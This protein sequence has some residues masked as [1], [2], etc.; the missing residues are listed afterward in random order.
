MRTKT[1]KPTLQTPDIEEKLYKRHRK[2]GGVRLTK[3]RDML[4]FRPKR[5]RDGTMEKRADVFQRRTA[6]VQTHVREDAQVPY[7][8]FFGMMVIHLRSCPRSPPRA[9]VPVPISLPLG[10]KVAPLRS[11]LPMPIPP[12]DIQTGG[13]A[14]LPNE[15]GRGKRGKGGHPTDWPYDGRG[16]RG[17][18]GHP[19]DWPYD[20]LI[21]AVA[22]WALKHR[23]GVLRPRQVTDEC[24]AAVQLIARE[25][26][27]HVGAIDWTLRP[28]RESD[29][30]ESDERESDELRFS[31]DD[32]LNQLT[33]VYIIASLKAMWGIPLSDTRRVVFLMILPRPSTPQPFYRALPKHNIILER[34]EHD[35]V[36]FRVGSSVSPSH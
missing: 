20:A 12:R 13:G 23:N 7:Y 35:K 1:P 31:L 16:K 25:F 3:N 5:K 14:D 30:R 22:V 8:G 4:W 36:E 32:T 9:P 10:T 28:E 29:E 18:G 19:T 15:C 21:E 17:K 6:F 26:C 33:N 2:E 24:I 34:A 27:S 11:Y